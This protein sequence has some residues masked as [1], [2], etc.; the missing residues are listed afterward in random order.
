MRIQAAILC[1]TFLAGTAASFAAWA[2]PPTADAAKAEA[3]E[4]YKRVVELDTSVEGKKVPEMANWLADKFK[5][6]GFAAADVNVIPMGETA[7][8][9]VRYRG[10]GSGGKPILFI[11]HMDVVTAH[12]SDWT[13]DPFALIEEGGY[14]YG[15]GSFDNK[16]GVTGLSATFLR[17]KREGFKPKRDMVLVFSGDEETSGVTT[18]T[19]IA[20]HRDLIDAEFALNSDAGQGSMDETTGKPTSYSMQT[21]EKTFGSFTL[22]AHNP[23]GHSSQPRKDNAIFDI[24]DALSRI[25]AYQFPV[26]WNDTTIASLKAGGAADKTPLGK[27]MTAFAAK[28]GDAA[29]A[30][31]LSDSP[32]TVGQIRTTCIP[33]LLQAGHADNALPQSATATINCRIF[34]GVTIATVQAQLQKLAGKA[35]EIK[36]LDEY[37]SSDASPLRPDVV[38]AVK[39]AV[40]AI[41]LGVPVT[42]GMSAGATDG[43]FYRAA[44]IPTYGVGEV[45]IKDSDDFAHGLN[46]RMPVKTFYE[47]LI[48]WDTLVRKIAG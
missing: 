34:P 23:G 19:L 20:K 27:A 45:F 47:G 13:R 6:A 43:V 24:V 18:K 8:L 37:S 33:T 42:P 1:A 22:T 39:A 14:F 46:E 5:A 41:H 10:D 28:P 31:T 17:L 25:R 3:R 38:A 12:K 21:A 11:G 30:K 40:A 48:Y 7:A 4:I 32:F 16:S 2:E 9:V 26:Q 36:P 44:G 35:I 29:A 15:R